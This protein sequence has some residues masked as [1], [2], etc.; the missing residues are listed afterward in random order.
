MNTFTTPKKSL[1]VA[2]SLAAVAASTLT[3]APARASNNTVFFYQPSISYPPSSSSPFSG[4]MGELSDTKV[5]NSPIALRY[6]HYVGCD[7]SR[8][9]CTWSLVET[10]DCNNL[11]ANECCVDG[12][13]QSS[14]TTTTSGNVTTSTIYPWTGV[15][16]HSTDVGN[17]CI[18]QYKIDGGGNQTFDDA[19]VT[20]ASKWVD[21][22]DWPADFVYAMNRQGGCTSD[23]LVTNWDDNTYPSWEVTTAD[24]AAAGGQATIVS[25]KYG[26]QVFT[27]N[28]DLALRQVGDR[29]HKTIWHSDTSGVGA[30][31]SFQSDGNLCIRDKN[32]H[33]VWCSNTYAGGGS[34]GK[35]ATNLRIQE[36]CNVT[37]WSSDGTLVWTTDTPFCSWNP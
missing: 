15:D 27:E 35:A 18:C 5:T 30:K 6:G 32:V 10:E 9:S 14:I 11:F 31:V 7:F 29:F 23:M 3:A 13:V 19:C 25:N 37:M 8:S 1:L 26:T 17:V 36:N 33:I 21:L 34:T 12:T 16:V 20:L 28:G 4:C 2:L 22:R 24:A